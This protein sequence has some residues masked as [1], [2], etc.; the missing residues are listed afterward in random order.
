MPL[1]ARMAEPYIDTRVLELLQGTP[2][3]VSILDIACG[4]GY[5]SEILASNGY[6]NLYCADVNAANF[7]LNKKTFHFKS[8]NANQPLPYKS[9]SFDVVISSE[10]IE[11]LENPRQFLSEVY[12]ILKPRGTF[13]LTTPSVENIISRLYFLI[14]GRLAFHTDNDYRLS[15]HIAVLPQWLLER[16]TRDLGLKCLA[17][18]YS[19]LYL[20]I[21][22]LRFP[23]AMFRRRLFGWIVIY[24]F[25][26]MHP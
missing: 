26:K 15:G 1:A 13:I 5:L 19:S 22:K 18:T 14:T 17:R 8:V 9:A 23:Q 25:K 7:K 3:S 24:K 12:R 2:K 6:K 11:H 10:T 21:L 20:P 16:F 4:Q